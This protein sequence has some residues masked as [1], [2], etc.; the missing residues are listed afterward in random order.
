MV[1]TSG[2]LFLTEIGVQI[3]VFISIVSSHL[4]TGVLARNY[5]IKAD[6]LLESRKRQN[7]SS[8]ES[9][10]TSLGGVLSTRMLGVNAACIRLGVL[11]VSHSGLVSGVRQ[12]LTQ[13][14]HSEGVLR[15]SFLDMILGGRRT[16][17]RRDRHRRL[18]AVASRRDSS[19]RHGAALLRYGGHGRRTTHGGGGGES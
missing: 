3:S 15:F 17:D 8:T 14:T 13:T 18:S 10:R 6:G 5:A 11:I 7:R 12:R 4:V 9:G 16:R 19:H 1:D 2:L